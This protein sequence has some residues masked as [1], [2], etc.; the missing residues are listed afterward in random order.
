MERWNNPGWTQGMSLKL[1]FSNMMSEF[2]GQNRG[3]LKTEI[4]GLAP[5]L[6]D[7]IQFIREGRTSGELGFYS[8][9]H[10]LATAE[11]ILMTAKVLRTE[12]DDVLVLGI[13]GSALGGIALTQALCHPLRNLLT[14]RQRHGLPRIFFLENIDPS[15]FKAVLDFVDPARTL[16]NVIT[17]SGTTTETISQFAVVHKILVD[18]VGKDRAKRH[19]VIT[20]GPEKKALRAFSEDRGFR[21][22]SIPDNVGGRYSVLT[23]VGLFPA[24]MVG[25]DIMELLAGARAMEKRCDQVDVWQNPAYMGAALHY[26]ADT[27]KGLHIAVIMPY[28]DLLGKV[29]YWFRQLWAESLGKARTRSGAI[30]NAGQTPVAALGVTDQHSQLQL[31][32][33]GPFDKMITFLVADRK[34]VNVS[35]PKLDAIPE[36]SHLAG[37]SLT[38]VLDIEAESTRFALTKAGRSNMSIVMPEINAYTLGQLFF[39]FQVQTAFAGV[40]YGIDPLDQPGVEASK[41]Y[42]YGLTGRHGYED[43]AAEI[44]DWQSRPGK[45]IIQ[46]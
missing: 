17:K 32:Q 27:R 22:F 25:I 43:K 26:V 23:P 18:K 21:L 38:E 15:T 10:D 24:A 30:V 37:R 46:T 16:V 8:L 13:G 36:F 9:P 39:M 5:K 7:A 33:E 34:A 44:R 20:T 2:V 41:D 14:K 45:Y 1:D 42:I 40:L 19:V 35:I 12:F 6:R 3:I 11:E 4:D 29:G 31:Y 28:S